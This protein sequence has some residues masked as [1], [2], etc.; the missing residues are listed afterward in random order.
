MTPTGDTT[1]PLERLFLPRTLAAPQTAG[2]LAT[3]SERHASH[4]H[5]LP[6]QRGLSA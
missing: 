5:V 1:W 3:P 2:P 4:H 6:T